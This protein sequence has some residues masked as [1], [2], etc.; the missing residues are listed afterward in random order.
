MA[1]GALAPDLDA[2]KVVEASLIGDQRYFASSV[3]NAD[4]YIL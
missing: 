4:P 3:T 2:E 1:H